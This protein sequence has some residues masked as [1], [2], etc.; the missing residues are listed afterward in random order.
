MGT[1]ADHKVN[2]LGLSGVIVIEQQLWVLGQ[3]WVA[4]IVVAV[5][6]AAG[7]A[8][9]LFGR[10]AVYLLRLHPH[11]ILAASGHNV[12]LVAAGAQVAENLLHRLVGQIRKE[13]V[14]ARVLGRLYPRFRLAVELFHRHACEGGEQDLLKF[15]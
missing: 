10:D 6:G 2:A 1:A 15:M 4:R 7:R 9:D 11:E 13:L 12:S 5:R 14:P 3:Y 8:D